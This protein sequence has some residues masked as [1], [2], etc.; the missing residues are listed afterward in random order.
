[1]FSF[2]QE[3]DV[4]IMRGIARVQRT[5]FS[6]QLSELLLIIFMHN[7]RLPISFMTSWISTASLEHKIIIIMGQILIYLEHCMPNTCGCYS[8]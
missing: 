3:K 7:I 4:V 8:T 1:M 2:S 6:K 5:E